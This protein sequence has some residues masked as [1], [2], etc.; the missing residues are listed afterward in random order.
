M[1]VSISRRLAA[2][3]AFHEAGIRTTCFISPIFPDITD[4]KA[5]IRRA[6]GCCNL[7]WLENLN[8]RGSYKAV[9]MDYI[10]IKHP[11]TLP[12][13]QDIYDRNDRSYWMA[14]DVELK[15]Y[16]AETD[17][18]YVTNDDSM[19]R[20]FGARPVVVN[21]FYHEQI[22]KS[23]R[24]DGGHHAGTAGSRSHKKSG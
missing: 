7:I 19:T 20:A 15:D 23:A 12:L 17:L 24:K 10:R 13:Y 9:I 6:K 1:A 22:K 3:K 2:M 21:Y 4:V 14:L 18:D 5:I 11:D 16:A 8:L